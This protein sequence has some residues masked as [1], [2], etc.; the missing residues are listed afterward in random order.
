MFKRIGGLAVRFRWPII[1]A[2]V[3]A[4][5]IGVVVMPRASEFS[6][7]TGFLAHGVQSVD[8]RHVLEKAFPTQ[9]AAASTAL[10]VIENQKGL[11][12]SDERY[13]RE[14]VGKVPSLGARGSIVSVTSPLDDPQLRA[15]LA[16]ADGTTM[17]IP[18]GISTDTFDAKTGDTVNAIRA[19]L[20]AAPS[21]T[22]VLVSGDAGLGG[23]HLLA[24][25]AAVEGTALVT[26]LLISVVLLLVYRSPVAPLVPLAAIA[27]SAAVSLGLVGMLMRTG[28]VFSSYLQQMAIVIIFGAGTDYCLFML[29]RYREEL[30]RGQS[31]EA[32]VMRVMERVGAVIASSAAVVVV[33]FLA[34][35]FAN[36][37]MF[38]TIGP[39][40]ALSV[41]VTLLAGLTLVPALLAVASPR[42]LFWPA[43]LEPVSPSAPAGVWGQIGSLVARAPVRVLA[44]GLVIL[45]I[46]ALYLPSVRQ[47]FEIDRELPSTYDSVQ[48]LDIVS[49]RFGGGQFLPIEVAIQRSAGWAS[50]EGLAA[51]SGLGDRLASL[52]GV[53]GIRSAVRPLGQPVPAQLALAQPAILAPYV[54]ADGQTARILA[55]SANDTYA[56]ASYDTVRTIRAAA[57]E[58]ARANGA[59]VLVG[60]ASA[61]SVD[62][63]DAMNGD[64]PRI[65]LFASVGVLLVIGLLL[66]SVVAPVFL[67]ASVF[68]TIGAT[69][70]VTAFVFQNL[71]SFRT[72]G[73][74]ILVPVFLVVLLLVLASDYS[75]FLMSRV[76]EEAEEH[77]LVAGIARGVEHTGGVITAAGVILAGTL[78][79][80]A[81]TPLA[82]LVQIGFAIAF[83]VLVDT[84]VVRPLVIPAIAR[85]LG[86]WTWW[87]GPLFRLSPSPEDRAPA[88]STTS[89]TP[90][91]TV[92]TMHS[93]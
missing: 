54:S 60:G 53:G 52:N 83:G 85:L 33:G 64:T 48:G 46:P 1:V 13:A 70:G 37:E 72:T 42:I 61:E 17:L 92:E 49:A 75:I 51:I 63:I 55:T 77:G 35:A 87:P 74:D 45:L 7:S 73:I 20:P 50:P 2:W 40:L 14:L 62:L 19:G 79:T 9:G 34:F 89:A 3:V 58:W 93:H 5:G 78:G 59:T 10:I 69:L 27:M 56:N 71:L 44:A 32:A 38:R 68:V 39:G 4:T 80:L 18:V 88:Q 57:G 22:R 82:S 12:P 43:R 67:L 66:R 65:I 25:L 30:R 6:M 91:T 11:T 23:D 76:K 47:T 90:T 21:G 86:R 31:R 26:L 84:F 28:W 16:S 29:S 8:A 36:F 81:L 15:S 41:A 24:C